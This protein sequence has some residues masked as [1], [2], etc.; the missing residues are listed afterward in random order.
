MQAGFFKDQRQQAALKEQQNK[1]RINDAVAQPNIIKT[2]SFR[3]VELSMN[4]NEYAKKTEIEKQGNITLIHED[5]C[6]YLDNSGRPFNQEKCN[7]EGKCDVC[8]GLMTIETLRKDGIY[9]CRYCQKNLCKKC[10]SQTARL[11]FKS[12]N[13]VFCNQCFQSR[14]KLFGTLFLDFLSPSS[15]GRP[16]KEVVTKKEEG[17]NSI[18]D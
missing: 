15:S 1:Q 13:T 14:K 12:S 17:S 8:D 18:W 9:T 2:E 3:V 10:V 16:S 4:N 11:L 6:L 7:L 5:K